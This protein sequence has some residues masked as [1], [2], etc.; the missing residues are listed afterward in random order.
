MKGEAVD[1][2]NYKPGPGQPPGQSAKN[3]PFGIVGMEDIVIA[4]LQYPVNFPKGQKVFEGMDGMHHVPDWDEIDPAVRDQGLQP[5]T[6]STGKTHL[7]PQLFQ[8]PGTKKSIDPGTTDQW[9][10][11]K[12]E[13]FGHFGVGEMGGKIFKRRN[14]VKR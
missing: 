6:R 8:S 10:N 3:S 14:V 4:G 12:V 7:V 2:M 1:G 9:Q 5:S 11:M 13:D